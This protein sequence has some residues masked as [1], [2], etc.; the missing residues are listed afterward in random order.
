M[1]DLVPDMA[2]VVPYAGGAAGL[3][4]FGT[5]V[6]QMDALYLLGGSLLAGMLLRNAKLGLGP[7][8]S[9][10][11]GPVTMVTRLAVPIAILWFLGD[12]TLMNLLAYKGG[13]VV[14]EVLFQGQSILGAVMS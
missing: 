5:G 13:E 14:F 4:L 9:T 1:L 7:L 12:L 8:E 11:K 2:E 6:S 10:A 3:L